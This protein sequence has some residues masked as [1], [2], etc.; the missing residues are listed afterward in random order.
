VRKIS[1][2]DKINTLGYC[3]GGIILTTA[4]LLLKN[5]KLDW[6]KSM[7]HMTVMLD[8]TDPGDI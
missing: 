8:H 3:I 1:K 5:R 6:I 7:G 4:Y 2:L